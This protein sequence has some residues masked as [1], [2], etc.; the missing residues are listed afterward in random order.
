MSK[1][2][3]SKTDLVLPGLEY[4][5]KARLDGNYAQQNIGADIDVSSEANF[6]FLLN[7][8]AMASEKLSEGIRAFVADSIKLDRLLA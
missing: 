4:T 1:E 5:E 7:Q 2:L 6:R 8:N 3:E